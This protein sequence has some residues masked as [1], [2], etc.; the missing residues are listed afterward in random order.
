LT[1]KAPQ[2]KAKNNPIEGEKH[3]DGESTSI[4]GEKHPN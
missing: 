4:E 3:L 1:A 2:L